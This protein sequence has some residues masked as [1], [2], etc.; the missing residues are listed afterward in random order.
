MPPVRLPPPSPA[1]AECD[2]LLTIAIF[3]T[4]RVRP[5]QVAGPD[6]REGRQRLRQREGRMF[7]ECGHAPTNQP[8]GLSSTRPCTALLHRLSLPR[9]MPTSTRA[10]RAGKTSPNP[11]N[12][13]IRRREAALLTPPPSRS[14]PSQL[15][16]HW[17]PHPEVVP[18][19]QQGRRGRKYKSPPATRYHPTPLTL[20]NSPAPVLERPRRGGLYQVHQRQDRR[21]APGWWSA[22][23]RGWAH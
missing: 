6:L 12:R 15:W 18:Q 13:T 9:W 5:L 7:R 2:G 17:L 16:C 20:L 19:G 11:T 21:Q 3:P 8:T 1:H 4:Y 23:G 10:P 22:D 14:P